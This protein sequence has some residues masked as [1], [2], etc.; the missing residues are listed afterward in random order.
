MNYT[1]S[2]SSSSW[3]QEF[4]SW[5]REKSQAVKLCMLLVSTSGRLKTGRIRF[6]Q[7]IPG[8]PAGRRWEGGFS[9]PHD[10]YPHMIR[11]A[12]KRL[13]D[14]SGSQ[15]IRSEEYKDNLIPKSFI[16]KNGSTN[17]RIGDYKLARFLIIA[18]EN[19]WPTLERLRLEGK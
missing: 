6:L 14:W 18:R 12:E 2:S 3:C 16:F 5:R 7:K 10:S 19:L 17:G 8:W 1:S 13:A 9:S 15:P 4:S 11:Q